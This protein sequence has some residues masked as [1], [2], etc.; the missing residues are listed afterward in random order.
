[1]L[2]PLRRAIA[3]RVRP[4][5]V[6][7]ARRSRS[8]RDP[9]VLKRVRRLDGIDTSRWAV[10]DVMPR[11]HGRVRGRGRLLDGSPA[12]STSPLPVVGGSVPPRATAGDQLMAPETVP[13]LEWVDLEDVTVSSDG[14]VRH[15]TR[16]LGPVDV[17]D[18]IEV[19]GRLEGLGIRAHVGRDVLL[20]EPRRPAVAEAAILVTG[21]G[22]SDWYHWVVEQLP[23]LLLAR[24]LPDEYRD[25]PLLVPA[26]TLAAPAARAAIDLLRAG[27]AV[28]PIPV[29][30]YVRARRLVWIDPPVF[31][32]RD[33]RTGAWPHPHH[34]ALHAPALTAVRDHVLASLPAGTFDGPRRVLLMDRDAHL[35][36]PEAATL[37]R[38]AIGHGHTP[39]DPRD[40]DL[41]QQVRLFAGAESLV[42]PWGNVWANALFARAGASG[43]VLAPASFSGWSVM[44]NVAAIPGMRQRYLYAPSEATAFHADADPLGIDPDAFDQALRVLE[45][46]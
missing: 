38:I 1:M 26:A 4:R 23:R 32:P 21:V 31:G 7:S 25:W 46:A 16:L 18:A 3:A 22:G 13:A 11:E 36:R 37:R 12:L 9:E 8:L 35:E 17:L 6:A 15:G 27:R 14:V 20:E 41:V 28:V 44:A 2:A 30:G 10:L 29:D 39:V 43:I 34:A 19:G 33:Y 42:G 40:L 24:R 45:P 5:V